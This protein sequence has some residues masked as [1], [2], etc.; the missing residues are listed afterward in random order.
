[1]HTELFTAEPRQLVLSIERKIIGDNKDIKSA[2][3]NWR[4]INFQGNYLKLEVES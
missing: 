2:D 1:M 3:G 4:K